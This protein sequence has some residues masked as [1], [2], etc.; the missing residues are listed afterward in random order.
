MK[1]LY[2]NL[3]HFSGLNRLTGLFSK[4]LHPFVLCYHQVDRDEMQSHI[5]YLQQ[6]FTIKKIADLQASDKGCC[7]ITLDDCIREDFHAAAQL[8]ET[9][10][11]PITFYIPTGYAANN[12][13]IWPI[14]LKWMLQ[15]TMPDNWRPA[16]DSLCLRLIGTGQQ[17]NVLEKNADELLLEAGFRV[18]AIPDALRVIGPEEMQ[19]YQSSKYVSWG[20]HS[21]HHPFLYLCADEEI[22]IE[23]ADSKCFIEDVTGQEVHSFCYP[24]GSKNIIGE[25]APIITA[26]FYR[27]AT[28]LVSGIYSAENPYRIPRV[29]VYPGESV[30]YITTKVYHFQNLQLIKA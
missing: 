3:R 29:G 14:K 13:S 21:V 2:N 5:Q 24:Y 7:A 1:A 27:N 18:D 19:H 6:H 20:S 12:V 17:T 22:K 9:M 25:R 28:T 11:F 10:A 16:F 26:N 23:L 8:A 30:A 15:Q 4:R